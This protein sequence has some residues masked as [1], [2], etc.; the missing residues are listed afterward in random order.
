MGTRHD[1]NDSYVLQEFVNG[2]WVTQRKVQLKG[3]SVAAR[4]AAKK[5][6]VSY[7]VYNTSKNAVYVEARP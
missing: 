3:G 6:G 7:R 5:K 2:K 4:S 1:K